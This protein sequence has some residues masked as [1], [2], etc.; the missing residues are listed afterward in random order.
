MADKPRYKT[1]KDYGVALKAENPGL[2]KWGDWKAGR[3]VHKAYPDDVV[4]EYTGD[5]IPGLG[6]SIPDPFEFFESGSTMNELGAGITGGASLGVPTAIG[7]G[8]G[9]TESTGG[10][11]PDSGFAF[12][13]GEVLGEISTVYRQL[14]KG[15]LQ[16][17]F[18]KRG[19]EKF[20]QLGR[21]ALASAESGTVEGSKAAI[22]LDDPLSHLATGLVTG[23]LP[24]GMIRVG[25]KLIRKLAK[26]TISPDP[27]EIDEEAIAL[28]DK[29]SVPGEPGI[30][31][32]ESGIVKYFSNRI[33]HT[34]ATRSTLLNTR[35]GMTEAL[36]SMRDQVLIGLGDNK[37]VRTPY[38]SGLAILESVDN[39][40]NLLH[41]K[42]T[43]RYKELIATGIGQIDI[44]P[45]LEYTRILPDGETYETSLISG[46]RSLIDGATTEVTPGAI[47]QLR[48][49]SRTLMEKGIIH[50]K[51]TPTGPVPPS[52]PEGERE[53][54]FFPLAET[55]YQN[56]SWW[57][58]RLQEVGTKAQS[59]AVRNNPQV[60]RLYD[61]A[62]HLIQD[63]IDAQASST[64]KEYDILIKEARSSWQTYRFFQQNRL[65]QSLSKMGTADP[66][67][68]IGAIFGSTASI[69]ETKKLFGPEAYNAARQSWL[70]DLLWDAVV[71]DTETNV[72][73][74]SGKKI[75]AKL[76]KYTDGL[77][78]EYLRELFGDDGFTTLEGDPIQVSTGA[79]EKFSTFME[80]VKISERVENSLDMLR[81]GQEQFGG[82]GAERSGWGFLLNNALEGG[83][84]ARNLMTNLLLMRKGADL[85]LNPDPSTN[86]FLGRGE[87]PQMG[88][89]SLGI[90]RRPT[91]S[92]VQAATA[93]DQYLRPRQ[94]GFEGVSEEQMR[95]PASALSSSILNQAT[96]SVEDR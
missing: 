19:L 68:A 78:S 10:A 55:E 1:Y 24:E 49:L 46:L 51:R 30:F 4:I 95:I 69:R 62:Y 75:R 2:A 13:V 14:H 91:L 65:V 59:P 80:M 54:E 7:R 39:T 33:R 27:G 90:P 50:H 45:N 23:A 85:Y 18:V 70:R 11:S 53:Y 9:F 47:K 40:E 8:L 17:P 61:R 60:K 15:L 94:R 5:E 29:W 82:A 26:K 81:G 79:E 42:G 12:G 66:E 84:Q 87:L 36:Q 28:F 48:K 88:D 57:W 83:R 63:A 35:L 74:V 77:D 20:P 93:Q 41:A 72:Q 44:D 96:G 67:K 58:S 22:Q 16:L 25:G 37:E 52:Y 43:G 6:F 92:R 32:P 38:E 73:Y 31:R 76:N 3:L 89:L 86:I 34:A 71:V 64:S 56:Y 21:V